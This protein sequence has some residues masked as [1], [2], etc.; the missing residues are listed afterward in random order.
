[1]PVPS[2][3]DNIGTFNDAAS[4]RTMPNASRLSREGRIKA[5]EFLIQLIFSYPANVS[6]EDQD[7]DP[8]DKI[9]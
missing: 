2:F 3:V 5:F 7:I 4:K 8:D 1:M 9:D 6:I